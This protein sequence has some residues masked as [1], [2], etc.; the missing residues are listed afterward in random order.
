MSSWKATAVLVLPVPVWPKK[1]TVAR[2]PA[3][4]SAASTSGAAA[5][6]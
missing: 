1:M 2:V 4:L 6:S 3:A 5:A